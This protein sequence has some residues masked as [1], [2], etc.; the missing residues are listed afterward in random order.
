MNG[1]RAILVVG[2]LAVL[3]LAVPVA[4]IAVVRDQG[5]GG[6]SA[7]KASAAAP[8]TQ[9]VAVVIRHEKLHCHAWSYNGGAYTADH[10]A[11][12]AAGDSITVTNNDVMPHQL[13]EMSGP[14]TTIT[15]PAMNNMGA[16][17]KITFA[18][19]G[20]YMFQ[21]K[22]GEDYTQGIQTVGADNT[23]RMK[24]YVS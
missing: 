14:S 16:S 23:L 11:R 4:S 3:L 12:L 6:T 7:T 15:T 13:V 21:T 19:P 5:G 9:D 22:A 20:T 1:L 24:V 10:T 2:M 18:K 8:A 17:A